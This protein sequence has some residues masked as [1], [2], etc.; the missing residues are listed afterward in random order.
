MTAMSESG[1]DLPDELRALA[2]AIERGE[3]EVTDVERGE[4]RLGNDAVRVSGE[5][6]Q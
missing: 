4:F 5:W 3:F 1:Y 2:D 6:V